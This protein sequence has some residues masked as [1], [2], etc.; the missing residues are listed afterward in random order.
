MAYLFIHSSADRYLGCLYLM[1]TVNSGA[2]NMGV[3]YL[4][5][6]I[7]IYLST[8]DFKSG[9]LAPSTGH[10]HFRVSKKIQ[11]E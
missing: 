10:K 3:Q 1:A 4:F 6:I 7:L 8:N 9:V 5:E 11:C 2:V